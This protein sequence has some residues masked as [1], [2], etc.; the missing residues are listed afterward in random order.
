MLSCDW[1]ESPSCFLLLPHSINPPTSMFF[2]PLCVL[3]YGSWHAVLCPVECYY[4]WLC[5]RIM[6]VANY[7]EGRVVSDVIYSPVGVNICRMNFMEMGLT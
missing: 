1:G 3:L 2:H 6:S 4:I 7:N 5:R